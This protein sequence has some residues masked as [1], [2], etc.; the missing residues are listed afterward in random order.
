MT[1]KRDSAYFEDRL[2]KE[3]PK[4]YADLR[5]GKIKSTRQAAAKA[6]LIHLPGRLEALMREW[7]RATPGQRKAFLIW[8]RTSGVG[9][10][11][12][13]ASSPVVVDSAGRLVPGVAAFLRKWVKDHRIKPGR[14]MKQM[15]FSNHDWRLSASLRGDPL[16]SEVHGRLAAWLKLHGYHAK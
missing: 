4:I 1:R 9:L 5:S 6:G 8:V 11:R 2:K 12:S 10:K 7:R 16:R 3:H 14:V 13:T 15:G